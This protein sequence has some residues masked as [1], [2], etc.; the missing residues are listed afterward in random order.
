[1]VYATANPTGDADDLASYR[2]LNGQYRHQVINYTEC[3]VRG[4][5]HTNG[6]ENFWSLFKRCVKGTYVSMEPFHLFRYLDEESF[7]F[8][9]RKMDDTSRFVTTTSAVAGKRLTYT[10]LIGRGMP[11]DA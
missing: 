8:N 2:G 7:R 11:L 10:E 3:Y 1:M 6:L 9:N 4:R 5:L